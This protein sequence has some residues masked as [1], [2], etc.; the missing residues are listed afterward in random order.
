MGEKSEEEQVFAAKVKE[1]LVAL[2]RIEVQ[3]R[4][5]RRIAPDTS[6]AER[7]RPGDDLY[8]DELTTKTARLF[9]EKVQ[10]RMEVVAT[11][12]ERVFSV[13]SGRKRSK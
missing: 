4:G 9:A 10:Q 13:H 8:F 11:Q 3:S 7:M 5:L 6:L 2:L 1:A 12:L